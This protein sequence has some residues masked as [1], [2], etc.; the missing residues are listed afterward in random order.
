MIVQC[1]AC[2]TRFRLADE[3][4]KPGGTKVRCS[5]CKEVF[6][7]TLPKPDPVE[8]AVDFDSSNM[9]Q[10]TDEVP[11]EKATTSESLR[12]GYPESDEQV[13]PPTESDID[14]NPETNEQRESSGLDFSTLTS[15]MGKDAGHD[16]ELAEDFS[17]ADTRQPGI[18]ALGEQEPA[19]EDSGF[20]AGE[21]PYEEQAGEDAT[22]FSAAFGETEEPDGP[23]EFAFGEDTGFDSETAESTEID[24]S[25]EEPIAP[26]EFSFDSDEEDS[27]EQE[28]PGEF[29]FED[30]GE[31]SAF[32]FDEVE[33]EPGPTAIQE[34]SEPG[35]FSFE[36]DTAFV[37]D[38]AS[39]WDEETSD[40]DISF[41]F[42][43]PE[44]DS[45]SSA[46]KSSVTTPEEEGLQFGEIDFPDNGDESDAAGF[47]RDDGFSKAAMPLI[48]ETESFDQDQ[49]NVPLPSRVHDG[50]QLPTTPP[51]K[52]SPL[53]RILVLLVLLLVSL[54]GA[55]GFLYMQEGSLNRSSI[56]KYLP[57]L[58]EYLGEEPED[59]QGDRIGITIAGGSYV[60]GQAGQMLVIQGT[61][62]NNYPKTRSAITVKG[63]LLD[64]NGQ[65]LLQQTVFCGNKLDDAALETMPFAA[66]EEAMNN[67]FG[68]GLSNMNVAAGATI[69][70]TI[71]FRN[72]PADIANINVEVV[73]SKPGA[74]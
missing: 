5:R 70:F 64:S 59:T 36:D 8:E 65:P 26:G 22:D 28:K 51:A 34:D 69:P 56:V 73:D 66:I 50:E 72:L 54:A 57:F 60:N 15:E 9:E 17:F 24:F 32:S 14:R 58:Q 1:E 43:E 29:S 38:S 45:F 16:D 31:D 71:V 27:F 6:T 18:D 35:E 67:Q 11:A 33:K 21:I 42:E 68:E 41:N 48:K 13:T 55:A 49:H 2:Q 52:K 23:I 40:D 63:V 4:I 3:K 19:S 37:E 7:V 39:A 61:A 62:V 44:F 10:V 30:E 46:E 20:S 53:S 74:N 12:T 25:K 47:Q